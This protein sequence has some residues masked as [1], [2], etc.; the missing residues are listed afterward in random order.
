MPPISKRL[1]GITFI[2]LIFPAVF[3]C[4]NSLKPIQ[5]LKPVSP[6]VFYALFPDAALESIG[7]SLDDE[8]F[9][10]KIRLAFQMSK[11]YYNGTDIPRLIHHSW[12]TDDES[13]LAEELK[14]NLES[15]RTM[16]PDSQQIIW[17]D[18]D[19]ELFVSTFFSPIA[20]FFATI[21]KPILKADLFRYLVLLKFGGVYSDLD[22][23]C[24]KPVSEWDTS[25]LSVTSLMI[26]VEADPAR[27]DWNDWYARRLQWV[28]WTI[29]AKPGHKVLQST[30]LASLAQF[31]AVNDVSNIDV[32]EL[33]GP[34]ILK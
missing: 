17:T 28:Q 20:Q 9:E 10:A 16:N 15:F 1:I 13:T 26:G 4:S 5:I 19:I 33:T 7:R 31:S 6:I 2:S 21:P 12:K 30:V 34:G 3:L 23:H 25:S 29:A 22:T 18:G 24:L 27:E 8:K 32:M 11:Q 14:K